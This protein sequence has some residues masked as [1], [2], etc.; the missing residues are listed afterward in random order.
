[1]DKCSTCGNPFTARVQGG[2]RQETC[3]RSCRW[4]LAEA[5]FWAKV[6]KESSCWIWIGRLD[7]KGYG[8]VSWRN[9]K[10]SAHRVAYEIS[11]SAIPPGA[12]VCHLCDVR[13]CVNPAHLWL[14][15]AG[16]NSRDA[17]RKGRSKG[18]QWGTMSET[19]VLRARALRAEGVQVRMIAARL[20]VG[21]RA[22]SHALNGRSWTHI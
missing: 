5:R 1:M 16:A 7:H 9:Q 17:S 4:G 10:R 12:Y 21:V 22:I 11:K 2:K 13:S 3:S 18:A 14:G 8:Q 20:G 19:T 6:S 15:D